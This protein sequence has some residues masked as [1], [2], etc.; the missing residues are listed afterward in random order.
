[1]A[2]KEKSMCVSCGREAEHE[3]CPEQ[4]GQFTIYLNY[5]CMVC[6]HRRTVTMA[7]FEWYAWLNRRTE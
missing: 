2:I 1:M 7:M 3:I 6:G 4:V 5:K